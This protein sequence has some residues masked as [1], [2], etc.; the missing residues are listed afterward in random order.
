[1]AD[2]SLGR[3]PGDVATDLLRALV[4]E[5]AL[6]DYRGSQGHRLTNNTG[7]LAALAYLNLSDVLER[8]ASRA[9]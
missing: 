3:E 6:G 8:H 2:R 1:V 5:I 7:Y 9:G 4:A